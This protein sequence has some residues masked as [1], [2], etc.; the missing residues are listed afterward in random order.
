[1][2]FV[3]NL[4]A[5]VEGDRLS[6][7]DNLS[8][9][10]AWEGGDQCADADGDYLWGAVGWRLPVEELSRE[11]ARALKPDMAGGAQVL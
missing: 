6:T 4:E 3:C 1:M 10:R 7:V 8:K 11:A 9:R 2:L 5:R